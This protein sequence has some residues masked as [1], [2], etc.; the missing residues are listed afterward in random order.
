MIHN[1]RR[2]AYEVKDVRD[3][4]IPADLMARLI[5]QGYRPTLAY[6]LGRGDFDLIPKAA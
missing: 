2:S 1:L 3:S 4:D 6:R 5:K